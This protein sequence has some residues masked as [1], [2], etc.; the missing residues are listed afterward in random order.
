MF[1][2]LFLRN[3][4][5][6]FLWMKWLFF[7]VYFLTTHREKLFWNVIIIIFYRIVWC[8]NDFLI[9]VWSSRWFSAR[10]CTVPSVL[11]CFQDEIRTKNVNIEI[12]LLC[13]FILCRIILEQK[14]KFQKFIFHQRIDST[15]DFILFIVLLY[16]FCIL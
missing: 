3:F 8:C 5:D 14:K 1:I 11:N 9:L 6:S 15:F 12:Y 16:E 13:G 7:F 10:R 2:F 4:F